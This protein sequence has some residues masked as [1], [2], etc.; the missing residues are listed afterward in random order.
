M[1]LSACRSFRMY[2]GVLL[3]DGTACGNTTR[4][5][6]SERILNQHKLVIQCKA[7]VNIS[8]VE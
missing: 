3:K 1:F 5:E 6:A 2:L 7:N 8:I 4:G